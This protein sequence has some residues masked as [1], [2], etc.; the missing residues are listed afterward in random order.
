MEI[1]YTNESE[2]PIIVKEK[3]QE[4]YTLTEIRNIQEGKFLIFKK[5]DN[6]LPSSDDLLNYILD[7]DMRLMMIEM[8]LI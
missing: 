4:G 3:E 8:G 5:T 2:V 1:R 6:H 7:V